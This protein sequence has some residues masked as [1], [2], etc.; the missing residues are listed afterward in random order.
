MVLKGLP[1]PFNPFSIYVTHKSNQLRYSKFKTQLQSFEDT[2][3]C[4]HNLSDKNVMKLNNSFSKTTTKE[5]D[6]EQELTFFTRRGKE[7][8]VSVCS[9]N[10]KKNR[11]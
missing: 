5:S 7:R 11:Q 1:G 8:I 3:K 2:E 6:I 4:Q 10:Y 9:D